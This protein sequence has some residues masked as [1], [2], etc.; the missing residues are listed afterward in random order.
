MSTVT[1]LTAALQRNAN[2]YANSNAILDREVT[3]TW[4]QCIDRVS[5]LAGFLRELGIARG[6]RFAI[7][8]PN[9]YRQAELIYAGYWMGATPVPIN[10]RLA[11]PEIQD[12]LED[13]ACKLIAIDAEFIQLMESP[14]LNDWNKRCLQLCPAEENNDPDY[15]ASIANA[16]AIDPVTTL[17]SDEAILLYTGGTT[18]KSK[19]VTLSH[20]N[21]L[22]NASQIGAVWPVSTEDVALHLPP[23][24]HSA[25]LVKTIYMLNGAANVYTPK[26]NP[27]SLLQT[28]E[29]FRVTFLIMVPTIIRLIIES[30][31]VDKYDLSS[32]RQILYG[33]SPMPAPW[34][35]KTF[36]SF[37]DAQIV[38]AYGLTETSPLLSILD[39]QSHLAALNS[40]NHK[41][42]ASCG[43]PLNGIEIRILGENGDVLPAGSK[44]DIVVRGDNVFNGYLGMPELNAEVLNN[45]WF[46]TG[47]VGE[48]DEEG[49][50][51]L[52]DRK[53]DVIITG[54]EN[55]YPS[56]VETV[57]Y[58]HPDVAECAVIGIPDPIFGQL[59]LGVIVLK[60]GRQPDQKD[61]KTFCR[62]H[63]AGF[64]LPKQIE[65]IDALPKS[66]VGK[67]L[68]TELRKHFGNT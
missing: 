9:S 7:L 60:T 31:L 52:R 63:I 54:G 25:D 57:I 66:T 38:Q 43:R 65:F 2:I 10:F 29:E 8:S 68:K 12:I 11:P 14:E 6:D 17:E 62:Q 24:C 47:D 37:P 49:F 33:T 19:G 22:S 5:R 16:I 3:Y 40:A 55:V 56:E 59:V 20:R 41:V 39:H 27:E 64:K 61:I 21:I 23:M 18:G 48:L 51:Y 35:K 32:L 67:I 15:E 34:I 36:E 4:S 26:F 45:G 53:H 30:G 1:T 44:G 28:I 58:K 42:L 46:N 13:A 50:L